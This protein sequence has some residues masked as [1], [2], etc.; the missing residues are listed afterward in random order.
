M[1]GGLGFGKPKD[2]K[3]SGKSSRQ[4]FETVLDASRKGNREE[5]YRLLDENEDK[6]N[7][8][9]AQLVREYAQVKLRNPRQRPIQAEKLW[10]FSNFISDFPRGNRASNI[11][12]A[13]AGFEVLTKFFPRNTN[14][15][16]WAAFQHNLGACY[17]QR[18]RGDRAENLK[19][20][21]SF[22]KAALQ[23]R[24]REAFSEAWAMTQNNQ[25][26]AYQEIGQF[27][28]A[29]AA[30]KAALEVRSREEFPE[31]WAITQ[32]NL[33]VAYTE[34][35]QFSEAITAYQASLKVYSRE[36]F[37]E[38]WAHT[39][40]NLGRV[41]RE[42]GQSEQAIPCLQA[43]LEVRTRQEFPED[44]AMTQYNLA[45]AY[46]DLGQVDE[47]I[48]YFRSSL[49]IFQPTAF[50]VRR[51]KAGR[52]FGN[53][54][55]NAG[56]WQEA[57]EGYKAA[58]E[59]VEISC[60]WASS[61]QRRQEILEEAMDVYTQIVQACLNNHQP[62]LAIEYVERSK[63]RNLVQLF[64]NS[65][66]T[67]HPKGDQIR[68]DTR[69]RLERLKK[70][71][72]D[73]Q[74]QLDNLG[75]DVG[76]KAN[77]LRSTISDGILEVEMSELSNTQSTANLTPP[78]P[79]PYKGRGETD[80]PLLQGEGQGERLT[81]SGD[82]DSS[83]NLN[84]IYAQRLRKE[85]DN[86]QGKFDEVLDEILESDPAY[87]LTQAVQPIRFEEILDQL[88]EHTAIIEWYITDERFFTFVITHHHEPY[89]WQS[90]PDDL[91][92]LNRWQQEY[93]DDYRQNKYHQWR[94]LLTSRL[95]ELSRILHLDEILSHVPEDCQQLILIP[96]RYLHLF[97][98]HALPVRSQASGVGATHASP[99]QKLSISPS[100]LLDKFPGGVRYAPSCQLLQLSKKRCT[101]PLQTTASKHLFAIQNPTEDL[102][103]A[104]VEVEA[105]RGY[106]DPAD[107]LPTPT[108]Q[109]TKE[110]W[111]Q[112][113]SAGK[114]RLA[115]F[116]HFSCHGYFN[117]ESPLRSALVLSGAKVSG[118]DPLEEDNTRY[119][120]SPERDRIDLQKCLLL[121]EIFALDL[122]PCS[123]V[124]LSAC[125]TGLSDPKSLSDEYIS[126]PSGF[127]VAGSPSIVG[128]QWAVSDLAT[129]FL[130]IKFYENLIGQSQE[131]LEQPQTPMSVA[132]ALNNAQLWLRGVTKE[133]LRDWL[134]L[135]NLD[136]ERQK[137]VERE[138]K[139][140]SSDRPFCEPVYWAAFCA[141]GQ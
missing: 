11:E 5:V 75:E 27:S 1:T 14:P 16:G 86:L 111:N 76:L 6:L 128:S 15:L 50:P 117:F 131:T 64:A 132:K 66:S 62:D 89:V 36:E 33:G 124:T 73:K 21:I 121:E 101:E 123:L 13:I 38:D 25:G 32:M 114:L 79:L 78:T 84:Q 139:L 2:G 68:P 26:I 20:A 94:E 81:Q 18:I 100:V 91:S 61:N 137:E 47:A 35:G 85:L 10:H 96:H 113:A 116:I 127:L 112:A 99:L 133:D 119:I 52:D 106:F 17:Q 8:N 93:L 31:K 135:L 51:L 140:S 103:F 29:I 115:N 23:V 138:L 19:L 69:K 59:A 53:T 49:E 65:D 56:K 95:E 88:E 107:I 105:I 122:R 9:F 48:T 80:S 42:A 39:Q 7:D 83:P 97:P 118:T 41:Y 22:Y 108:Q 102:S 28:E 46:S 98:L 120:E 70:Q 67:L 126:L 24:T 43:A 92:Q 125:E 4:F 37:P 3:P 71:I 72:V 77:I 90:Q 55:F 129:A 82:S 134:R 54:A 58:I 45:T 104:N 136:A 34:D 12:I 40:N 63:A 74:Q 30:Y 141:I 57:I 44:W 130:M 110:T 109:A 60:S 87:A